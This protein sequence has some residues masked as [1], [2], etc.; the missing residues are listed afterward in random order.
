MTTEEVHVL[1]EIFFNR[2]P[3]F[4]GKGDEGVYTFRNISYIF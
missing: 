2:W 3:E 4:S 1:E